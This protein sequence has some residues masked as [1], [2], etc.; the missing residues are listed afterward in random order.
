MSPLNWRLK[1]LDEKYKPVRIQAKQKVN[2]EII[3]LACDKTGQKVVA[4]TNTHTYFFLDRALVETIEKEGIKQVIFSRDGSRVILICFNGI[5]SYDAWGNERWAYKTE[6]DIHSAVF[7]KNS[8]HLAVSEGKNLLLLDKEGSIISRKTSDNFVGGVVFSDSDKILVGM[9]KGI[10]CFDLTGENLWATHTGNLILGIAT[11]ETNTIAI[12]GKELIFINEGGELIWKIIV[13]PHR[14][15]SIAHDGGIMV[16]TDTSVRRFTS[17]GK[18]IWKVG[19]DEFVETC[20][21][22]HT[23]DFAAMAF[24]GEIFNSHNLQALDGAGNIVWSY[25][26]GQNIKDLA[27]PEN[28]GLVIAALDNKIWWFQNTGYLKMRV[29]LDLAKCSKLIKK[30]SA[31]EPDLRVVIDKANSSNL[32]E[33]YQEA[34]NL[35]KGNHET[36]RNAYDILSEVLSRLEILHIRHVEYLDSLPHFLSNLG[37]DSNLPEVLIPTLYPLYSLHHDVQSNTSASLLL[38]DIKFSIKHLKNSEK[39]ITESNDDLSNERLS[40]LDSGLKA[41]RKEQRFVRSLIDKTSSEKTKVETTIKELINEWLQTGKTTIDTFSLSEQIRLEEA[42]QEDLLNAI[43]DRIEGHLAFVDQSS[44]LKDIE[45]SSLLFEG[46]S[47][48]V[49]LSGVIKNNSDIT[50]DKIKIRIRTEGDSLVLSENYSHTLQVGHLDSSETFNFSFDFD[51]INLDITKAILVVQYETNTGQF[52]TSR[53]GK[54]SSSVKDCFTIPLEVD[55]D[56]HSEKRAEYRKNHFHFTF[57]VEGI[58]QTNLLNFIKSHLRSFHLSDLYSDENKSIAYHSA[59][60]NLSESEYFLMS[61]IQQTSQHICEVECVCYS[62]K[63][64]D[65][66]TIIKELDISYK[67][68]ILNFGGKLV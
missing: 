41:L 4:S 51:P 55:G 10:S 31:Y 25:N 23:G 52:L 14:S 15:L 47:S 67:E 36:L 58:S 32:D 24:G 61:I 12:S 56:Y 65:A 60:S 50:L 45:L 35:S 1:V 44:D 33:L 19:G 9:D 7:S 57:K 29:N 30:V 46:Q 38:T 17:T 54:I 39:T 59:Q 40:F 21:F 68:S 48:K 49:I 6:E 53:L 43:R 18:E 11:S 8:T 66:E 3:S 34:E 63:T 20:R 13:G 26:A 28:G 5:Y 62:N 27:I 16:A 22:M 42:A 37:L 2:G 64:T